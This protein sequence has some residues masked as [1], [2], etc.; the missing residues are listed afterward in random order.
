MSNKLLDFELD[1]LRSMNGEKTDLRWGAAMGHAIES[2]YSGGYIT[3]KM[4]DRGLEY[5][6]TDKGHEAILKTESRNC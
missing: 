6:L 2:L 4:T 3:R 5:M 1:V